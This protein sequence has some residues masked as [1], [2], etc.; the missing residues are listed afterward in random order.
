MDKSCS[1][2]R[3]KMIGGQQKKNR[4][5]GSE[6]LLCLVP[7]R[8]ITALILMINSLVQCETVQFHHWVVKKKSVNWTMV[9]SV[10]L[11]TA[12]RT[13]TPLNAATLQHYESLGAVFISVGASVRGCHWSCFRPL[14]IRCWLM[15]RRRTRPRLSS[16]FFFRKSP[17]HPRGTMTIKDDSG[18]LLEPVDRKCVTTTVVWERKTRG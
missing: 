2:C 16:L 4:K 14:I 3:R 17:R 5:R 10:C 8:L 18:K 11:F 6:Q 7:Y 15:T 12:Q 13:V 1:H 9:F